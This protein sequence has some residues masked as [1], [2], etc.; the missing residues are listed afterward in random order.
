MAVSIHQLQETIIDAITREVPERVPGYRV[1]LAETIV[2][3]VVLERDHERTA[4]S[5]NK[6]FER[7]CTRAGE[8]LTDNGFTAGR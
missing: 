6:D 3:L 4:R 5:I 7:A 2:Q 8:H 1:K